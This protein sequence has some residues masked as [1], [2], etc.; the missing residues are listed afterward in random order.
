MS[1]S[2]NTNKKYKGFR[3]FYEEEDTNK[4][5]KQPKEYK[6]SRLKAKQK[7]KNFDPNNFSEEDFDDE[8][9]YQ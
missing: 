6:K 5:K 3:E 7:L 1:K 8:E 9:F 2:E 4:P